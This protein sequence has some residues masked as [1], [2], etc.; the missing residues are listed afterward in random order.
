MTKHTPKSRFWRAH[1]EAQAKSGL[2]RAEYCR[3][4]ELSYHALTYWQSK[5]KRP[6]ISR[7]PQLIAVPQRTM[8]TALSPQR[9]DD[10]RVVLANNISIVL[11][12]TFSSDALARLLP[13]LM[14]R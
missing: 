9:G 11:S 6:D 1:V 2:N 14:S 3:Q 5:L 8:Q 13:L 10:M 7:T 4:H 12:N